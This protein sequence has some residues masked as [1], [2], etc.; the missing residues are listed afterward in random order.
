MKGNTISL[1]FKSF[2]NGFYYLPVQK[3][4]ASKKFNI[5]FSV[6]VFAQ[7][8]YQSFNSHAGS[9]KTHI[10]IFWALF[11]NGT[12][13]RVIHSFDKTILAATVTFVR[14]NEL[15]RSNKIT[16]VKMFFTSLI[17]FFD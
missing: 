6:A 14:H 11:Q 12:F 5:Q 16:T 2:K 3:W 9:F 1:I 4:L 13:L 10:H 17:V 15:K 8:F 7:Y